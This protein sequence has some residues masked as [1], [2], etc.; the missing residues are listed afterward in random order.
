M[1]NQKTKSGW[2]DKKNT[3]ILPKRDSLQIEGHTQTESEQ[4]EK[5]S[6]TNE[7]EKRGTWVAQSIKH[8]TLDLDS[9]HDVR[10][11]KFSPVSGSVLSGESAWDSLSP[12]I[13][14]IR[15]WK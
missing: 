6:D 3:Y 15:K 11:M 12:P 2:I 14:K 4:M 10:V 7:N 9:G 1:W 13:F 5:N 8:P